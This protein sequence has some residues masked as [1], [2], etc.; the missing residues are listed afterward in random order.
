MTYLIDK[1][2]FSLSTLFVI[3]TFFW[4]KILCIIF[5]LKTIHCSRLLFNFYWFYIWLCVF[6]VLHYQFFVIFPKL[7][8]IWLVVKVFILVFNSL[9][10]SFS[11]F[12]SACLSFPNFSFIFLFQLLFLFLIFLLFLLFQLFYLVEQ[13]NPKFYQSQQKYH[14]FLYQD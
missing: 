7:L 11:F 3:F 5:A 10:L 1:Q 13:Y 2:H 6:H 8:A 4:P 9:F 12:I 14:N